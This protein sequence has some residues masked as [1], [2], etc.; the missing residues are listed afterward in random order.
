MTI[1]QIAINSISTTQSSV[2]EMLDA[3]S[4][5]GFTKVEFPPRS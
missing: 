5:A 4:A 2:E 1:D 3:Y